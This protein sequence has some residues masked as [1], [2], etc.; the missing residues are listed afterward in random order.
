VSAVIQ[1]GNLQVYLLHVQAVMTTLPIMQ[2]YSVWIVPLV[3]PW[4][5]GRQ[6]FSA[7]TLKSPMKEDV[8]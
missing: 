5:I 8:V 1:A 7:L 4:R 2:G 6:S 3:T